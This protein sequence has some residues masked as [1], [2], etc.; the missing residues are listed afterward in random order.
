MSYNPYSP[1]EMESSL[2]NYF[3]DSINL[4]VIHNKHLEQNT[5]FLFFF[6]LKK[7]L[8]VFKS[9]PVILIAKH[10]K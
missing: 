7:I 8:L 10:A 6:F 9:T 4:Q 1:R 3:G 2:E 5:V